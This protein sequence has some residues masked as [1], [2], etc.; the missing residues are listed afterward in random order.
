MATAE[1]RP[2][3]DETATQMLKALEVAEAILSKQYDAAL[4]SGRG[5]KKLFWPL[6]EIRA[7]INAAKGE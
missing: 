3:L 1:T 6:Q 7:A 2:T 5:T 4:K